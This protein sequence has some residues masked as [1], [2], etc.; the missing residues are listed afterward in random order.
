MSLVF[1]VYGV[2]ERRIRS[3]STLR[4]A[5]YQVEAFA[6]ARALDFAEQARPDLIIVALELRDRDGPR[7]RDSIRKHPTLFATPVVLLADGKNDQDRALENSDLEVCIYFPLP[8]AEL[9]SAVE[10][11]LR[12]GAESRARGSEPVDIVI[13]PFAMTISVRGKP[14]ATTAL[15]FRF[16]DYLARH[17]GK[18]FTRDALLDAVWGDLRFVTPRSV[19]ACVRR[20]RSK[21]EPNRSSPRLLLT[22]RG[23][24]YRLM[25]TSAWDMRGGACQCRMCEAT[26][27][28]VKKSVS[29]ETFAGRDNLRRAAS[30]L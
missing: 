12:Q 28:R 20:L 14:I 2:M 6:T 13:D 21:I 23:T 9:L 24:G 11:A 22:V 26:R 5:G 4:E 15:E 1:L 16:L 19:D 18:A 8:P 27:E 25:A 10:H 3:E 17:Q 30:H 29:R 7:I